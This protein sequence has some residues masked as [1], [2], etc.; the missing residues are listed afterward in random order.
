MNL[1]R[2]HTRA[3]AGLSAPAVLVEVH[4]SGG[5]PMF[6]VSGLPEAAVKESKYRVRSAIL[7][8]GF[9]F[10]ARR[11]TVNLAPADL[12]KEGARF[13]LAIAL[14]ILVASNQLS[15]DRIDDYECIGELAL[16]GEL[17]GIK[18]VLPTALHAEKSLIV[19]QDNAE[20]A[21]LAQQ[22]PSYAAAHLLDVVAHLNGQTPLTVTPPQESAQ[23]I[24]GSPLCLSDVRGQYQAKRALEIAAAGGHNLLMSGPPGTG[25]SMLAARL[26]GL[27]PA[28]TEQEALET[29]SITSVSSLGFDYTQWGSRPFRTPHHSSSAPAL[30]GGG[31][32]PQPGEISLAHNGALFLDELPE[33][34]RRALEVLREPLET[35][36][37]TIARASQ[38]VTFPARFQLIAAMNPTPGGGEDDSPYLSETQ[39]AKYRGRI[40]GPLL[41]RIDIQIEV[42][43]IPPE[44]L[45]AANRPD[46]APEAETSAIVRERVVAARNRQ[47]ERQGKPNCQLSSKEVET[48]CQALAE[49]AALQ[50]LER[51][52][53]QL[54]LSAR[55][56]HRMLKLARTIADL[57]GEQT[58][59]SAHIAEAIACRR[60]DRGSR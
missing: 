43:K 22:N 51:A 18:G 58:I 17:R 41:D 32:T 40:S 49:P 1:A 37:I 19:P 20:E 27:L 29:A 46:N 59:L 55:A 56:Y 52:L 54:N 36:E 35:G 11:I 7:T 13:D 57:N 26:P 21:A 30:V 42:P 34:E 44:Q 25:K 53:Q 3:T 47:L 2:I 48:H 15:A 28:M 50:L 39:I 38:K 4:L 8:S 33:F 31:S 9:E 14:G 45:N 60:G 5:L 6:S 12:P 10:P 24:S 23:P 16:G